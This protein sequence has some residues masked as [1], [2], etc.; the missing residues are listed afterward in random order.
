[1]R[2]RKQVVGYVRMSVDNEA[3]LS[4]ELQSDAIEAWC[5]LK[6]WE[7]LDTIVERGRSA[8]ERKKRPGLDRVRKMIRR[9]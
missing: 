8:G 3:K 2:P 6:D 7:L 5:N 1:M 4:P 9:C